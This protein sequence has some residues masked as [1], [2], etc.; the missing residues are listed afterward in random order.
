MTSRFGRNCGAYVRVRVLNRSHMHKPV[1]GKG[2]TCL[3]E[4]VL[5]ENIKNGASEMARK[6]ALRKFMRDRK[7]KNCQ[8]QFKVT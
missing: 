3:K 1:S 5:Q 7:R 6:N 8:Q 2:L 4:H